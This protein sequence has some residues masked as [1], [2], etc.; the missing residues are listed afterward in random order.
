MMR[1]RSARSLLVALCIALLAACVAGPKPNF[2]DVDFTDLAGLDDKADQFTSRMTLLGEIVNDAPQTV[3]YTAE[4]AY[5]AFSFEAAMGDRI[6]AR[7]RA[8]SEGADGFLWLLDEGFEVL[9]KNDDSDGTTDSRIRATIQRTGTYYLVL[10]ELYG[11]DAT[12]ELSIAGLSERVG[13]VEGLEDFNALSDEAKMRVL[14]PDYAG[15]DA[16]DYPLAPEFTALPMRIVDDLE[17]DA[18]RRT[19]ET[20]REL[21]NEGFA[22]GAD[23]VPTVEKLVRDGVIWAIRMSNG[24]RSYGNWASVVVLDAEGETIGGWSYAD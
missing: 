18:L 2:D 13:P 21:R 10:R 24:G 20:Y 7:L 1:L 22:N 12:F 6:D 11:E 23:G 19:L 14:F 16:V 8:T 15:P 4:P 17:G 9:V 5:R 3:E